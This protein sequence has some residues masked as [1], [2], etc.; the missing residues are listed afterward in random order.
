MLK[1]GLTGGI[2]SGKSY[3]AD[4]FIA[5]G[6][7]VY[8]ADSRAKEIMTFQPSVV[9]AVIAL[10]GKQAYHGEA[11]NR[12]YVADIVFS[13]P[14]KLKQLNALVHPEVK[15]D[16][17]R[18]SEQ[19]SAEPYVIEEAA[20]L[21]ESGNFRE[22]DYN[23]LVTAD[24]EIRINRVML[25]DKVPRESVIKRIRSQQPDPEKK[26]LAD[27]V[28]QNDGQCMLLPLIIEIHQKLIEIKKTKD[29]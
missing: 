15:R 20:L 1:V 14:G 21:F 9:N 27:F 26:E 11:L 23:I 24:E 4:I 13:N 12:K 29:G 3:V 10:F 28:V 5:L 17:S 6:V 16:F 7:R 2:G 22:M 19:F 18:W 25:R 8:E